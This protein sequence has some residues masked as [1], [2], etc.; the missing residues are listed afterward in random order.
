VFVRELYCLDS[1]YHRYLGSA[2]AARGCP[3]TAAGYAHFVAQNRV[4]FDASGFSAHPYNLAKPGLPPNKATPQ[5]PDWAEFADIL[6]L[7]STVDRALRSYGSNKAMSVWNTEYGYITCPPNCTWP[8]ANPTTAAA[9]INWAEYLAW[10]NPSEVSSMQYLL[11]DP[12][13]RVGVPEFGGFADGLVFYGGMPKPSY[14]AYRMPLFLPYTTVRRGRAL[15]VWG[16]VRPAPFAVADGDGPQYVRIQFAR[17]GSGAWTTL[18]T[19]RVTDPHGYI[20]TWMTFPASGSVRLQWT[21]PPTDKTL[22]STTV[23]NSNGTI[24]SRVVG[25]TLTG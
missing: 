22:R 20:D 15:E 19:L 6:N 14:Y 2:A 24:T 7:A 3:T 16:D 25:V 17:K 23:T 11:Y 8:D 12:N 13:P 1:K 21:Y 9:Y 10:R 4:L 5:E 18:R